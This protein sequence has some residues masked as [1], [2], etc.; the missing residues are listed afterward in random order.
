[1]LN[2]VLSVG[3]AYSLYSIVLT[4]PIFLVFLPLRDRPAC[5]RACVRVRVH[6]YVC[7]F[8]VL[9]QLIDFHETWCERYALG[10]Y[11]KA[12]LLVLLVSNNNMEDARKCEAVANLVP[13]NLEPE[14]NCDN[15]SR[16]KYAIFVK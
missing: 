6:A 14:V 2:Y 15:V 13:L 1:M 16:K 3:M 11:L 4:F 5:V 10:I 9:N 7:P 8:Q 12:L